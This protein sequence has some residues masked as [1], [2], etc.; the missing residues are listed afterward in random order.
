[1]HELRSARIDDFYT[2]F[3]IRTPQNVHTRLGDGIETAVDPNQCTLG[4]LQV[5]HN[6]IFANESRTNDEIDVLV[7][8]PHL[9]RADDVETQLEQWIELPV[10]ARLQHCNEVALAKE[11][12]TLMIT[13][14]ELANHGDLLFF[15]ISGVPIRTHRSP[16]F[17]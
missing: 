9:T 7:I 4:V 11:Q 8:E 5:Q 3:V 2:H 13:N 14:L 1:M 10:R 16:G 6:G 15:V 17:L 12:T